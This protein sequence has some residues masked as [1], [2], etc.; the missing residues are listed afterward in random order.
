MPQVTTLSTIPTFYRLFFTTIDPLIALSGALTPVLTP[1]SYLSSFAPSP[2]SPPTPETKLCLDIIASCMA[3][4][5]ILQLWLLR[6]RPNDLVV[7]RG[8]QAFILVT[9]AG[10]LGG[11]GRVLGEQGRLLP[12]RWR[13]EERSFILIVSIV[14]L[15]RSC[16]LLDVGMQSRSSISNIRE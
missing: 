2:T 7:W 6:R 13:V 9:D 5:M 14:A 8:V 12:W 4:T 16:F 3:G 10:I 11:Y 1:R 15:I